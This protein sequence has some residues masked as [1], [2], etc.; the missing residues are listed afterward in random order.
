MAAGDRYDELMVLLFFFVLWPIVEIVGAI[1]VAHVIGG[2][3]TIGLLIVL[4]IF[5]MWQLKIQGLGAWRRCRE[6]LDEG[7]L[8]A[9]NMLDGAMRL[10]GSLLLVLPGFVTALLAI[11]LLVGP[12]R[13]LVTG[14]VGARVVARATGPLGAFGTVGH[15]GYTVYKRRRDS[16]EVVDVEGWEEPVASASPMLGRPSAPGSDNR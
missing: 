10:F 3:A 8:P 5:G 7:R 6:D 4:S 9:R 1:A 13:R 12:T 16:Q 11:P 15:A 14:R 2:W